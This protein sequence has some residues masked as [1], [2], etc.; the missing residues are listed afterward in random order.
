[1]GALTLMGILAGNRAQDL[2]GLHK[3]RTACRN[4]LVAAGRAAV[5]AGRSYDLAREVWAASWREGQAPRAAVVTYNMASG[6]RRV[7][8]Q[9]VTVGEIE[10]LRQFVAE[11]VKGEDGPHVGCGL[12]R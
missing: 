9:Q 2:A 3:P 4:C 12:S 7:D 10:E 1:M 8:G 6:M 11:A 5:S